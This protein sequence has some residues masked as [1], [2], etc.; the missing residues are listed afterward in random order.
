MGYAIH[1]DVSAGVIGGVVGACSPT[2]CTLGPSQIRC[3]PGRR[4][5]DPYATGYI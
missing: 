3:V 5:A 1:K 2:G 4:D